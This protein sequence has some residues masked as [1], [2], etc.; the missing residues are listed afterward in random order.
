MRVTQISDQ[1]SRSAKSN[2]LPTVISEFTIKDTCY[3]VVATKASQEE[4]E[5][6]VARSVESRYKTLHLRV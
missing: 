5:I 3:L 1:L 4:D 6:D 2:V